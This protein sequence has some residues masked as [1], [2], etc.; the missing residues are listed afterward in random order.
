MSRCLLAPDPTSL[1]TSLPQEQAAKTNAFSGENLAKG[2]FSI[3]HSYL[4]TQ[5]K[6]FLFTKF[7]TSTNMPTAQRKKR[8]QN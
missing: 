1:P 4:E 3:M 6:C 2:V 7:L 5:Y 8:A